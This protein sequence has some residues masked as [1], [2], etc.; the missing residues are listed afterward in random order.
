MLARIGAFFQ[1]QLI[2]T[3]GLAPTRVRRFLPSWPISRFWL[4]RS[5]L[6]MTLVA[7]FVLTNHVYNYWSDLTLFYLVRRT[8]VTVGL[9][10][11]LFGPAVLLR[12]RGQLVY[13]AI[14][15]LAVSLVMASHFVYS[16]YADGYLS[17]SALK[18]AWQLSDVSSSVRSL[19]G[20]ELPLFFM[21]LPV[22]GLAAWLLP[23]SPERRLS[24]HER[25]AV[26]GL[27]MLT[28]IGGYGYIFVKEAK[29][30]GTV[31]RLIKHP[32]NSDDLVRKVGIVNYSFYDVGRYLTRKKSL[33]AGEVE[34]V[35]QVKTQHQFQ[36]AGNLSYGL[37]AG[38]N[39]MY[40][41]LES[42]Q[43][44]LVGKKVNGQEV[45]PNL[46]KFAAGSLQ[47]TN[48]HYQIGPGTSSD[49]EFTA[50][51]SLFHL[52]DG[53][54]LFEYPNNR[55]RALPERLRERGYQTVALHG[56]SRNFW[57][58]GNAYPSLGY[59]RYD[60]VEDYQQGADQVAWG[61]ADPDFFEQSYDKITALKQPFWAHV[62]SLSSHGP[63]H[64][65]GE[66]QRLDLEGLELSTLQKDYLQSVNYADRAFGEFM[67]RFEASSLAANTAVA[68]TGDHEAFIAV[69]TDATYARFLGY[70]DGFNDLTFL[71][72]KSVPF[73]IKV[74]DNSLT[75]TI[76]DPASH[77]DVYP[78]IA[79]LAGLPPSR[80]WLGSDLL[81]NPEPLVARRKRSVTPEIEMA[82]DKDLTYAGFTSSNFQ[83]GKCYRQTRQ[84]V[85]GECRQ[86]FDHQLEKIKLSDLIVKGNRLDL[87]E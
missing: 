41:Q 37:L 14:V 22:I 84:V 35:N 39:I 49:A 68:V 16:S 7:L 46:N 47:F 78:T 27:I 57:N 3:A 70:E 83:D 10:V 63:F 31:S 1:Q 28:A 77:L 15:S 42:F 33:S 8:V 79:N 45:A 87:L 36:P 51:N 19:I 60:T 34:L 21:G 53:A 26:I 2:A 11:A 25:L 13:L 66:L 85:I 43:Q 59:E 64:L 82:M 75:G 56:D 18:Y 20:A 5:L 76:A 12:R 55:Y 9:G 4:Q 32:Y 73:M 50:L 72:S 6:P 86:L 48:F 38:K 44:W 65:P 30:Q 52:G 67:E 80:S 29:E 62:I 54:T 58:R 61:I 81:N 17:V 71:Q 40:V 74:P 69:Q 24:R 23:K